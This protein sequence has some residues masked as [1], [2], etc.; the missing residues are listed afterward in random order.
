MNNDN[1]TLSVDL[2]NSLLTSV[3]W[4]LYYS[5]ASDVFGTLAVPLKTYISS[6]T[7]T[8]NATPTRYSA[9]VAVPPAAFGRGLELVLSVGAQTSGTWD[10]GQVQIERGSTATTFEQRPYPLELGM[11]QRYSYTVDTSAGVGVGYFGSGHVESATQAFVVV[12]LP[13]PMRA[14]PT[15]VTV[16]ASDIHVNAAGS[17]VAS[18]GVSI[19]VGQ[20]SSAAIALSISVASG[21]TTGR[22][23]TAYLASGKRMRFTGAEL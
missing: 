7:F 17:V 3:T 2:A 12:P 10:I 4:S 21:L 6:G 14:T 20:G 15:G 16:T 13:V 11:C 23:T 1:V 22:G 9:T 18:I 8:V 19:G 5:S